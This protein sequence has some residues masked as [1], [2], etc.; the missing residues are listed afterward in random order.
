M[1]LS[2]VIIWCIVAAAMWVI[3]DTAYNSYRNLTTNVEVQT[4]MLM[5]LHERM[6]KSPD[7]TFARSLASLYYKQSQLDT[8]TRQLLGPRALQQFKQNESQYIRLCL[9]ELDEL[10]CRKQWMRTHMSELARI[11]DE[12]ESIPD[13]TPV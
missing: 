3:V 2:R 5:S 1:S 8:F 12:A 13:L 7:A 4:K 6:N 9:T 10:E 11:I